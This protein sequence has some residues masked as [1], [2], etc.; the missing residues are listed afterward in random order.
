VSAAASVAVGTDARG[1]RWRVCRARAGSQATS[2]LV[3]FY[4]DNLS[5]FRLHYKGFVQIFQI[6]WEYM[7]NSKK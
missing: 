6:L 3:Q 1:V 4:H 2:L 7:Q 5:Q